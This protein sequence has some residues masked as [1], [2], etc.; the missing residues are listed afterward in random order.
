MLNFFLNYYLLSVIV[1][2]GDNPSARLKRTRWLTYNKEDSLGIDNKRSSRYIVQSGEK[3]A[4][5]QYI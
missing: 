2:T 4:A 1:K 3:Q 5:E